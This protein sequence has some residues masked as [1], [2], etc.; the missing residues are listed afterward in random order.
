MLSSQGMQLK[1]K[2]VK[3]NNVNVFFICCLKHIIS[4][5]LEGSQYSRSNF[6][7]DLYGV[8]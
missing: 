6:L 5:L 8:F 3:I 1:L 4:T 7:N 2:V